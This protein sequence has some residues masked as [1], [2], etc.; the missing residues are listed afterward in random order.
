MAGPVGT[1]PRVGFP[2]GGAGTLPRVG[3]PFG[4][5][6]AATT[7]PFAAAQGIGP[8]VGAG[9]GF[10]GWGITFVVLFFIAVVFWWV[11]NSIGPIVGSVGAPGFF[12]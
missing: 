12:W 4:G 1:L 2:F 6:G 7:F 9:F 11:W 3:F 10:S 5:A 8:G